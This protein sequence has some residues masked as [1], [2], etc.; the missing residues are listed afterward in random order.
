[1]QPLFPSSASR[2]ALPPV[3]DTQVHVPTAE[4]APTAPRKGKPAQQVHDPTAEVAPTK[5]MSTQVPE[6][7][8]EAAP[9]TAL[10]ASGASTP[11]AAFDT[12]GASTLATA[13]GI[14]ACR[15]SDQRIRRAVRSRPT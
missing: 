3:D 7:T 11:D 1:M 5:D 6:P 14:V 9:A 15:G 4:A 13:A 10:V 2:V 8:A 12:A